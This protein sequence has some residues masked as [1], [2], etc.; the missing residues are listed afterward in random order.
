VNAVTIPGLL[1]QMGVEHIDIL[2]L[3][4]EGAK[5]ELFELR[6]ELWLGVVSLIFIELHDKFIPEC[7]SV[8]YSKITHYP[9]VQ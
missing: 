6:A 5:R 9:F 4:I 7:A 8:L 2:K 1:R 3:D